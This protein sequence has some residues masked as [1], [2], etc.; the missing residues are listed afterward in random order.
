MPALRRSLALVLACA[1]PAFCLPAHAQQPPPMVV[2]THP[3]AD[4][5]D[6][7][8]STMEFVVRFDRD[9]DRSSYSFIGGGPTFPDLAGKPVWRSAR[10]CVLP[11][12]LAAERDYRIGLNN[13]DQAGFRS[14]DGTPLEPV[15]IRFRTLAGSAAPIS[16]ATQRESAR[17]LREAVERK[18]SHRQT[19]VA[20]W[21]G[22]WP[23]FELRLVAA[24]SPRE[25]AVI[26]GE[27]LA[28][29]RDPHIWLVEAGQIVPAH[30]Q[31]LERNADF[32]YLAGR[33]EGWKQIHPAAFRG[34]AAPG[35]G[36]L[37]IN[38][39][40]AKFAPQLPAALLAALAEMKEAKALIL[41]V[42]G[43]SGGDE[44]IARTIAGCFV[45]ARV[46]YASHVNL[47]PAAPGGFSAPVPRWLEPNAS[48]PY[49][50]GRVAVLQGG[51]N[52]S[53][54]E[55]FLLMLKQVPQ[56]RSFGARSL[57][58]S[59]NPQ[60][61]ALA[62]GVSVVLPSWKAMRPDGTEF[63]GTGLAPEVEAATPRSEL[64][65]RDAVLE[66]ALEWLGS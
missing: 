13:A 8:V 6:V 41:D 32:T 63:E 55:A 4:R 11:I 54:A 5:A 49:F 9:M 31:V 1:V 64:R 24:K 30:R 19:R 27:Y 37:A 48:A 52:M 29:A 47:D 56:A 34:W 66:K 25:F 15:V 65:T 51:T 2:S 16:A 20:D 23:R 10:E 17:Q 35:I 58:A 60:P 57:G 53:S 26:A 40:E 3:A 33:I 43:N 61:H 21:S 38:S 59:G 44:T 45:Q 18:Y 14:V 36:Y 42:R 22:L 39:W 12:R 7:P 28:A 62:N 46:H 50:P